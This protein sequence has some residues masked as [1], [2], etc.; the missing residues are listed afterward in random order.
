[1]SSCETLMRAR[2]VTEGL[3]AS[4]LESSSLRC[5]L[6]QHAGECQRRYE[7][8]ALHFPRI[9]RANPSRVLPINPVPHL[10]LQ[11]HGEWSV[12]A[13][14]PP[15]K[16]TELHETGLVGIQHQEHGSKLNLHIRLIVCC[17]W[18]LFAN[19]PLNT[20]YMSNT[21]ALLKET[22]PCGQ[23][24]LPLANVLDNYCMFATNQQSGHFITCNEF[25]A[26]I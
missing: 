16:H 9:W 8:E 26:S 21:S 19:W 17:H 25:S 14:R 15:H 10:L 12:F 7:D 13:L 4:L 6:F 18:Q 3:M 2:P 5:P 24:M 1:M 22:D 23:C 20:T 11:T